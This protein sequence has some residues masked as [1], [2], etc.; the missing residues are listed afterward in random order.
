MTW[1]GIENFATGFANAVAITADVDGL[2]K[3]F[4]HME[5]QCRSLGEFKRGLGKPY[6]LY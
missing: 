4:M 5:A 1:T 6:L 2:Q 3:P